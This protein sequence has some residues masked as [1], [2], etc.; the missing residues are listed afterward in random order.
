MSLH[1]PV[2]RSF[3]VTRGAGP[4]PGWWAIALWL[5][6][7]GGGTVGP[8]DARVSASRDAGTQVED[9]GRD[10][11]LLVID[12]APVSVPDATVCAHADL[13]PRRLIPTVLFLVDQ[14]AS[15]TE[16]EFPDGRT[17]WDALKDVLLAED[18][19]VRS[20]ESVV[21]FGLTLYSAESEGDGEE[22][23]IVGTC[24]MITSV[25]TAL[26]NADEIDATLRPADTILETPTADAIAAVRPGLE[27]DRGD[28]R[29]VIV[30]LT[31]GDP[32]TCAMPN[33]RSTSNRQA[34][35]DR[36]VAEVTD[37][38]ASGIETFV[39][40]ISESDSERSMNHL[41]AMANAGRGAAPTA[42]EPYYTANDG[43]ALRDAI[44][45]IVSARVD[46]RAELDGRIDD[47]AAACGGT[48]ELNGR[49]VPCD[50][51]DGWTAID[52]D[53]IELR[54]TACEQFR[55]PTAILTASFPCGL[56]T[57]S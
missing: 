26:D 42:T 57:V 32:D 30:L 41:Q 33:P 37:A 6:A 9:A 49:A 44:A 39:V 28:E 38:F 52:A 15:M 17:R 25:P 50:P 45:E 20:L 7:C 22:G 18:G 55:A 4:C 23:H 5:G 24:P 54:G 27:L 31:D 11:S 2:L 29:R 34:A 40:R 51:V 19:P 10:A 56:F 21:R 53:T 47:I 3:D 36:A 12:A 14:S 46:C 35:M 1:R 43:T 16:N 13:R 8:S 48:V